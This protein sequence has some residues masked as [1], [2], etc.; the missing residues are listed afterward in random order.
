[1]KS[2]RW[3]RPVR[4]LLAARRRARFRFLVSQVRTW[5]GMR[6]ID[7]GCGRTGRSTTDFAPPSWSIVG[8]DHIAPELVTHRH[9]GFSYVQG[10]LR[11]LSAFGDGEFD[12]AISVGVLEHVTDPAAFA[13]TSREIQRVACQYALVVPYRYAWI[14]PHYGVPFFPVLPRR[15]QNWLIRIFD[16]HGHRAGVRKDPDFVAHRIR[17]RSNA[18]YRAAFPGSHTRLTPT[19]ETLAILGGDG[20]A[21]APTSTASSRRR[22][23]ELLHYLGI[24]PT[25]HA[26]LRTA[27]DAAIDEAGRR[28]PGSV[29]VLDAG[30]GRQS[31]LVPFRR[32]INRL[33]GADLHAPD[34]PLPYLDEFATV[35][36]CGG[37]GSFA[38]DTFDVILSNFTLE[39]FLDPSAAMANLHRWMRPDGTL[40]VTTVNRR[41]RSSRHTCDCR[42][43][44]GDGSSRSSRPAPPMPIRSSAPVTTRRPYAPR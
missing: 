5:D 16:L 8:F 43:V 9:R 11:D 14:E 19:R 21:R 32:R 17:W 7:L 4:R 31:P 34:P 38:D 41:H 25:M 23:F 18:E 44:R 33:V 24:E 1:M 40:V 2:D 10:D 28:S 37:D 36:L 15:L 26:R 3:P 39:H 22:R 29:A 13:D 12:L 30:C 6:V 27:I 35:D 42:T 20:V